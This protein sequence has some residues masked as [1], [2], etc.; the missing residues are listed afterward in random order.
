MQIKVRVRQVPY[1]GSA[2]SAHNEHIGLASV[3]T[4]GSDHS[5][6]VGTMVT[7]SGL[8]GTTAGTSNVGTLSWTG[9]G[10]NR[11]LRYTANRASNY[12]SYY[13]EIEIV[14]NSSGNFSVN[15]YPGL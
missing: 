5:V 15:L 6:Y 9:S 10:M 2:G 8:T 4:S 1:L 11:T 12:D 13:I 3:W 7:T 14:G